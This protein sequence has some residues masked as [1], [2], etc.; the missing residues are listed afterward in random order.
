MKFNCL[1]LKKF[2]LYFSDFLVFLSA[3]SG[4]SQE[5]EGPKNWGNVLK[6]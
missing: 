4:I 5:L 1:T 2:L 3:A 6:V